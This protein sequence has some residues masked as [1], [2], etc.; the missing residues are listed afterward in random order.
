[1]GRETRG[2][3]DASALPIWLQPRFLFVFIVA[4]TLLR[5]WVAADAGLAEDEAY[6]RIWGLNPAY[7]YYDHPPMVG[8]WIWLGQQLAGDTSLGVRLIGVLASAVGSCVIW[9]TAFLLFGRRE[10]G[11]SVLLFNSSLLIAAGSVVMTPDSPS[12]FFW[13]LTLWAIAELIH[14]KNANWWLV[15]GLVAGLGLESKYSVLFLGA[16]I[17][18]WLMVVPG[19]RRWWGRWQLWAGGALALA[20][21]APVLL[22][23]ADHEWASFYK[24]FGR[25]RPDE[26][27]MKYLL[28]FA[29]ALI[30]LIN[31][32][33]AVLVAIGGAQLTR[34]A[35]RGE[36]AASL[37]VLTSAPFIVYLLFHALHARVQGNWPAP[38]FPA[39]SMAAAVA[40]A[41]LP[42]RFFRLCVW[43]RRLAV[44]FG[45]VASLLFYSHAVAPLNDVLAAKLGRKDPVAQT[46]GWSQVGDKLEEMARSVDARWV[47]TSG[48]GLTG[49]LAFALRGK[50]PVE[51]LNERVRYL[52]QAPLDED[53]V[54]GAG[55]Y[56]SES[57][58]DK[59]EAWLRERFGEVTPLPAITRGANGA[60][61]EELNVYL[62][63]APKGNPR[64][65]VRFHG[66]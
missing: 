20:I 39:F 51:Q 50:L 45:V 16:G 22:W 63:G 17:V 44:P 4:A 37:I 32:L 13:G 60:A 42:H 40:A 46:R 54:A 58:K 12:V 48:Y 25:V 59:G 11:W 61:I 18:L 27:T 6:Y 35:W 5:L 65:P 62:V 24:Q 21:F 56:V 47:A 34:R 3:A 29:G 66:Q 10:A 14:D 57:R 31:P 64:E 15:V 7:G 30:G 52:M 23:N 19:A 9:R 33:T 1:M 49:Q 36:Q 38:L 53:V 2:G 8:W 41:H 26:W 55:L 28:E 43:T